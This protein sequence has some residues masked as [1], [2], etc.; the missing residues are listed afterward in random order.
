MQREWQKVKDVFAEAIEQPKEHRDRFLRE[1]CR[2]DLGLL[3]EVESLLEAGDTPNPLIDRESYGLASIINVHGPVYEGKDIGHY[4]VIREIGS[5][6]MGTVYLAQ[7]SDEEYRKFVAIKVVRRGIDTSDIIRRFRSERQILASLDYPN[8]ARL[9]DGGTTEDGLPYLVMEY[10]EGVPVDEYCD[11]HDLAIEKRLG[12]F[13]QIC[14]A[15]AFAHRNLVV[16]RDLKPSNIMVADDG[17]PKLL[18]FGIAKLLANGSRPADQTATIARIMTPQYASPEQV[19]GATITTASDIYSLGVLLY[20]L[21]TGHHPYRFKTLVPREIEKVICEE[22]PEKPSKALTRETADTYAA[23]AHSSQVAIRNSKFLRGDLDNIILMAMR[24]DPLRRYASVEQFSDDIR[25]HI[26]GLP[27]RARKDTFSYR[28]AKFIKRHRFGVAA[29]CLILLSLIAGVV[30]TFRQGRVAQRERAKAEAVNRFLQTMLNASGPDASLRRKHQDLT[31]KEVLD[32]AARRLATE[33]LSSEPEVKAEL[34]RII[35]VSYLS[36]GQYKLAED[37]LTA[38]LAAQTNLYGTDSVEALKTLVQMASLWTSTGDYERASNF[39]RQRLPLLRERQISGAMAADYLASSLANFALLRRAQ[40]DSKEAETLLRESLTLPYTSTSEVTYTRGVAEAVLALTLADQGELDEAIRM[41]RAKILIIRQQPDNEGALSANLTGLGSFLIEKGEL[42]EAE[43]KLREAEALYR[44]IYS[45]SNTQLG[46]NL[47]LQAQAAY[48]KHNYSE[49]EARINQTWEVYRISTKP[50]Y[51]NYAT[52]LTIQGLIFNQTARPV[53]AEK[54]LRE[55][56]KLRSQNMP[57]SHFLRAITTGALGEFLAAQKR[58]AEAEP[59]LL[60]S[61]E[62]LKSSQ[63]ASSPR[64]RIARERLIGLYT[65]WG[66]AADA[67]T[68]RNKL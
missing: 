3:E 43:E 20:K 44:K 31:V 10:V 50:Q 34:Q 46:D 66:R 6:G 51:I 18:D 53:E 63:T 56:L 52:A 58:F 2:D 13:E 24:K 33:D 40:G 30:A 39:Y 35:G 7:R 22:E 57:E 37:N 15:V 60:N 5:G 25:R 64:T 42:A 55:A 67:N 62:S 65:D 19:Q 29:A 54:I 17:I 21:L 32:E 28:G 68:Y 38:A 41:V 26:Q 14:S 4:R 16:H 59:L 27:V 47:R 45:Q 23:K 61:Y 1:I 36:R 12:I 49:A 9:L 8:I 48:M 11:R